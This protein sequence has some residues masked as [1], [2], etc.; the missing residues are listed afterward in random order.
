MVLVRWVVHSLLSS[1][2]TSDPVLYGQVKFQHTCNMYPDA[3]SPDACLKSRANRVSRAC[4]RCRIRKIKVRSPLVLSN[5]DPDDP[6][7]QRQEPM[8]SMHR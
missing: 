5:H 4:D 6:A 8:Q 2:A 1:K 7:V 3:E